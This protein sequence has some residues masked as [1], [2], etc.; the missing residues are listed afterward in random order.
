VRPASDTLEQILRTTFGLRGFWPKQ[1]EIIEDL[2]EGRDA[3]VLMPTGG[4]KSLCYQLPALVRPGVALVVSPLIS[5]MKDQVDALQASGIAAEFYNSALDAQ[6]ARRV[7][8]RL[9]AGELDLLYVAPER[10]MSPDFIERLSGV[11][12]ALIATDEAHCVSQWGHDFRPEY[13]ALG[14]L[15]SHFPDAPVIALTATADPQ[16]RADIVRVLGLESAGVHV[17]SFDRPNIRY[18]VLEKYQPARQLLTFLESQGGESGIVYALS[19]KRTEEIAAQLQAAG[20]D[21]EAYHAGLGAETRRDVQ[22]RFIRDDLRIVVATV[23]FGMGIDKPNVRFV[24]HH[25]LPKNIEGY[26]QET[27]RAGRD[28]LPSEAL[29][30][31]GAQDAVLARRLIEGTED[32]DQR[33]IDGQKLQAMVAFA[34]SLTCRRRV[35]LGYFG[36]SLPD[37]CGNCDICLNP[38]ETF[39]GTVLAQKALSCVYRVRERFGIGHVVEVLRGADTERIRRLGHDRLSTYGIGNDMS[40][41]EWTS[42]IRQ[43]IHQGFLMQDIGNYSVLKLTPEA[44]PVL[45][46]EESI[47]LAM[48]RIKEKPPKK[49]RVPRSAQSLDAADAGLFEAL[50]VLRKELADEQ[51]V[52]PYV[53]FGD[54]TLVEMSRERPSDE[55]D[56]I[57]VNGV[58][59]VKLER[60]GDRF[61]D[62]IAH[63]QS[64]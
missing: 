1:R 33:R 27:G 21:A 25:D 7:L 19:R 24:V 56:L 59:K 22:E 26:Y 11:P 23:A 35:L 48:P 46:G 51:G 57:E 29:L 13:A 8:A 10:L 37:D 36:E 44:R 15:R 3:F 49:K 58:G 63:Y 43:L 42:Y 6:S 31:F 20:H 4:G 50:R 14:G 39:D 41:G 18:R 5:L 62:A 54:A 55:D 38:P 60:Y 45:R 34:E 12:V 16:T 61:L 40:V 32:A 47:Q 53:I 30:L 2:V 28:G 17:S 52:P 64:D 9:H